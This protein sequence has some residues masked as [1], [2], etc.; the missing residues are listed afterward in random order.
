MKECTNCGEI[1]YPSGMTNGIN[2]YNC[3]GCLS[4]YD[5]DLVEALSYTL[6]DDDFVDPY[7]SY[8]IEFEVQFR[9]D[10]NE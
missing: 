6:D 7:D 8:D 9:D 3:R 2:Y 4:Q 5:D 10:F 1:N